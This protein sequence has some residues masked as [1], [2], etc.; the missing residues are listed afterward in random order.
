[1]MTTETVKVSDGLGRIWYEGHVHFQYSNPQY[2]DKHYTLRHRTPGDVVV[3]M[4][5]TGIPCR[6]RFKWLTR[7]HVARYVRSELGKTFTDV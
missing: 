6:H 5:M 1:M 2:P 7:R 4:D 3:A